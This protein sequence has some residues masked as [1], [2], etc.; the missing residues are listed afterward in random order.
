MNKLDLERKK[1]RVLYR[2]LFYE[3][4]KTFK[5]QLNK[6]KS[7]FT[8]S[9]C[10]SCCKI[11]YSQYSPADIFELSKQEDVISQEYIKFFIPYGAD[12][13]FSYQNNNEI[14][15][16]LNNKQALEIDN[17]YTG[18]VLSKS[19]E[20]IYFY[21]CRYLDENKKC[22]CNEKSFL[23]DNFPNFVTTI[24]PESC[25]FREWQ[26][27]CIDKIKNEIEPD[28]YVKVA[29]IQQYSNNFKCNRC[30]TCCNLACS[31]YSLEELKLKAQN[32]DE[33]AK[34]FTSVFIPYNTLDEAREI[35]PDYVDL[36]KQTLDEDENIYFYHC[37][38]LT[39]D[40]TCSNYDERPGICRDFPDNPLSILPTICGFYE[41]KEE[42]MVASMTLHAMT[43]IYKFY[44]EKIEAVL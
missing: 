8:C 20:P 34:Q 39:S 36:V 41:W 40:K 15:I 5:E 26:T 10:L 29:E 9:K 14:N 30:A 11:R 6:F 16:E 2:E 32:G 38:H 44:L 4:D 3:A 43:Y 27:L 21:F 13:L 42:V 35:F 33:F 1:N 25:S 31:E 22:I 28:I 18:S 12:K 7:D 23:C 17:N 24:L 19:F 37:P